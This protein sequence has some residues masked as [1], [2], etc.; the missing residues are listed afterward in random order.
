LTLDPLPCWRHLS[1]EQRQ[2]RV[3]D[4]VA[5]IDAEAAA[6][7]AATEIT[8][9]GPD[10]V[11]NQRPHDRPNRPKKSPAPRFHVAGKAARQDMWEAY[12]WFVGAYMQA[13][14]KLR[15]G[16]RTAAFPPGCFPPALPFVPA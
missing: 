8:P 11:R 13:A 4:L 12:R 1:S 15:A 7:R 10:F 3:A 9:H 2:R 6:R 14:E 5:Q 16:D